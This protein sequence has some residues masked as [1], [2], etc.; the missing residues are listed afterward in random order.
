MSQRLQQQNKIIG[1]SAL[2]DNYIWAIINPNNQHVALVD[3][4]NAN[5]CIE[6]IEKNQLILSAILITHHHLD[7]VGGI[8]ELKAYA[9]KHKLPLVIYGP[10]FKPLA[11]SANL[12]IPQKHDKHTDVI[13]DE[14]TTVGQN[15]IHIKSLN[16]SL[17]IMDLTGHTLEH[18]AYY[19]DEL[20]FCGDT[21]FSGGCGRIFEGS[22]Q[23][24]FNALNKISALPANTKVYCTHEYT[25]SNLVFA[26]AVEPNNQAL[27][28]YI[29]E[30]STLRKNKKSTLPTTIALEQK[31]NP[32]LRP[33][34]FEVITTAK[35]VNDSLLEQ[36]DVSSLDVFTAIRQWKNEF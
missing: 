20:I 17:N 1:I 6:Y 35:K 36:T 2:S 34:A 5:V 14:D 4:G 15:R 25:Q 21:L 16:L 10:A 19:N 28:T 3:P 11:N 12:S 27:Q 7:H 9:I 32:F 29:E 26:L 18:I 30:V 8:D 22:P 31:I 23:Q 24:M 33:H 13:V